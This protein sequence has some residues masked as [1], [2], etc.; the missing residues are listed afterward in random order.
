MVRRVPMIAAVAVACA[1]GQTPTA[2]ADPGPPP[3]CAPTVVLAV[4]GTKGPSTPDSIDPKSPV[5]AYVAPYQDRPDYL[6]KF[7]RY[8]GGMVAGVNGWDTDL[9]D[10]VRIGADHL[11]Q[12]IVSDEATCGPATRYALYGYSQGA[13]VVRKVATEIDTAGRRGDGTDL[14]DRVWVDLIADPA[15]GVAARF[16][17]QLL[18]GITLPEPATPFTH[19]QSTSE[20]LPGDMVCDPNG[21]L[22]GYATKH[23]TYQPGGAG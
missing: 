21:D 16:P 2:S 18:P 4:G 20:C 5:N 7:V 15:Q 8:P 23:T 3:G 22:A 17:G 6:V 1:S 12:E 13:I 14:Q 19:V 9:D 11:R 10:S